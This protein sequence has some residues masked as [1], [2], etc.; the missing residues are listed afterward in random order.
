MTDVD[1]VDVDVV[2]NAPNIPELMPAINA[3]TIT[4][5]II[6]PNPMAIHSIADLFFVVLSVVGPC[7]CTAGEV[8]GSLDPQLSQNFPSGVDLPQV[9]Q[10]TGAM[11]LPTIY[12]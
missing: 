3:D 9:G 12:F 1:P 5:R 2:F 7:G 6:P 4:R 10:I 8:M 11:I